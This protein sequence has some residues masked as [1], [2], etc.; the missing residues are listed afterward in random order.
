[1]RPDNKALNL[2]P[3]PKPFSYRSDITDPEAHSRQLREEAQ[4][5][6]VPVICLR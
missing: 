3:K 5:R 1:M 6:D 2:S 4:R